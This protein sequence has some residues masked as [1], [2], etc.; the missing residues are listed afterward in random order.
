MIAKKYYTVAEAADQ[1]DLTVQR[2]R[3]LIKS[4]Q[5]DAER[6]HER[7]WII[8]KQSLVEFRKTSRPHGVHI[9]HRN[10]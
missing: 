2:V 1:L 8:P 4:K 6:A 10:S 3:Q 5:L 7:L 9:D